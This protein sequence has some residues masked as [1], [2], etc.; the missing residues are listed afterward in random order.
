[1]TIS[2]YAIYWG[3]KYLLDPIFFIGFIVIN[4]LTSKVCQPSVLIK[5]TSFTPNHSYKNIG[6]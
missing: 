2:T 4:T 3:A 6:A 5:N 1:M